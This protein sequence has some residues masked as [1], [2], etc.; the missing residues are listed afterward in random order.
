MFVEL[1]WFLNDYLL[2]LAIFQQW[3]DE[4]KGARVGGTKC[5]QSSS[6][7]P[8]FFFRVTVSGSPGVPRPPLCLSVG[9]SQGVLKEV[10][11]RR[12]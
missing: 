9:E 8:D 4:G 12:W 2:L 11:E 10:G 1:E 3:G 6:A 5:C 7:L